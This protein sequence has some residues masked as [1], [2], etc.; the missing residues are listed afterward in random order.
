MWAQQCTQMRSWPSGW[1]GSLPAELCWGPSHRGHCGRIVYSC[2]LPDSG[3]DECLITNCITSATME[4]ST[5]M[6]VLK[7]RPGPAGPFIVGRQMCLN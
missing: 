3:P 2:S 4:V 5:V 7:A 1:L 6:P